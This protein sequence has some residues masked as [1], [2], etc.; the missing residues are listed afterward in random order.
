MKFQKSHDSC[1]AV[2][3][4]IENRQRG[5]YLRMGD[6]DI[7]L[8]N[9]RR[10]G[11]QENRGKI[12]QE[13]QEVLALE[14]DETGTVLKTF[15]ADCRIYGVED[16]Y[17]E[18][19]GVEAKEL[20]SDH[21]DQFVKT[22]M[23]N[24]KNYWKNI[25]EST[26]YS[27]NAFWYP[28]CYDIPFFV[29]FI[30]GIRTFPDNT[31]Y[32]GNENDDPEILKLLF[33]TGGDFKH[34]KTPP[35]NAYTEIDRIYSEAL[36]EV[37][38]FEKEDYNLIVIAM[39][40]GGRPL[41]KRIWKNTADK[42]YFILDF[43]SLI[44]AFHNRSTRGWIRKE[45]FLRD[46]VMSRLGNI[47]ILRI[48]CSQIEN[49]LDTRSVADYIFTQNE[50]LRNT[51]DVQNAKDTQD[52]KD[53]GILTVAGSIQN[54]THISQFNNSILVFDLSIENE[55]MLFDQCTFPKLVLSDRVAIINRGK[56]KIKVF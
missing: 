4:T 38:K 5:V 46:E 47:G 31:V 32:I 55:K 40:C 28:A 39:G 24:A 54:K 8:A 14:S 41:S 11:W 43:G 33:D 2:M 17:G 20:L 45:T 48:D 42:N 36:S 3:E 53:T 29:E 56:Y 12:T 15:P 16:F 1:I 7:E 52:P 19:V 10:A 22:Q 49:L 6:G 51:K 30:R 13:M 44:D 35:K 27:G 50:K 9:G 25:E 26:V 18:P 37:Q 34:I 23:K 21:Q